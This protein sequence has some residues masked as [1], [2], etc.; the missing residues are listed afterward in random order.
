MY[1]NAFASFPSLTTL[2]SVSK[3]GFFEAQAASADVSIFLAAGGAPSK[4]TTPAIE[5]SLPLGVH[6]VE[7]VVAPFPLPPLSGA[8]VQAEPI[9]NNATKI[10]NA[11]HE[12]AFFLN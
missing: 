5:P 2:S 1:T 7:P 12:A 3:L 11:T 9:P 10:V 8:L 6:F 4:E